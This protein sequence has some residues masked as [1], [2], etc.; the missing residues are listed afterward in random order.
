MRFGV[1]FRERMGEPKGVVGA[2]GSRKADR[3]GSNRQLH[4]HLRGRAGRFQS[5][6]TR[7]RSSNSSL[8]I[9]PRAYRSLRISSGVRPG[10]IWLGR[11]TPTATG[12]PSP[13]TMTTATAMSDD[14][15][16]DHEQRAE[17]H[18]VTPSGPIHHHVRAISVSVG[19]RGLLSQ[20]ASRLKAYRRNRG[21]GRQA[22]KSLHFRA[23]FSAR[24]AIAGQGN[25]GASTATSRASRLRRGKSC[26]RGA[27][28]CRPHRRR[29]DVLR[30]GADEFPFV[31]DPE[32]RIVPFLEAD[33]GHRPAA[34]APPANRAGESAGQ[35][36]HIVG[37]GLQAAG[38]CGRGRARRPRRRSRVP[39]G[40]RRRP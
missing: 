17:D 14:E 34:E 16:K 2:L 10:G 33:R 7:R 8:S 37:K 21:Q 20:S 35:D 13:R 24:E 15:N 31:F 9:S 1:L 29:R 11:M 3:S 25:D 26:V 18:A 39:S 38:G 30:H 40:R 19:L 5:P 28:F 12:P 36:L 4:R 22:P 6:R 27:Q 23:P 32:S